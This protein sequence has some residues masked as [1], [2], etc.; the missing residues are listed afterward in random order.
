M[1][2]TIAT[3]R[4]TQTRIPAISAVEAKSHAEDNS[5]R[6][7]ENHITATAAAV[8]ASLGL[9]LLAPVVYA[10]YKCSQRRDAPKDLFA[11]RA[12]AEDDGSV[13]ETSRTELD[14]Q[15]SS[16]NEAVGEALRRELGGN[17]RVELESPGFKGSFKVYRIQVWRIDRSHE[18]RGNRLESYM[19]LPGPGKATLL[20]QNNR[21]VS[22]LFA[23]VVMRQCRM[24]SLW[25]DRRNCLDSAAPSRLISR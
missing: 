6:T 16:V 11:Q 23:F 25:S 20:A 9:M 18:R 4:V 8:A 19:G 17:M 5:F 1:T 2:E 3:A 15:W 10:V 21:C 13:D 12:E 7:S 24:V 22:F 14:A